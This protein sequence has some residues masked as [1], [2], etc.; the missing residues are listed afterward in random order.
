MGKQR[1]E[2]HWTEEHTKPVMVSKGRTEN[3][4]AGVQLL[5]VCLLEKGEKGKSYAEL[6]L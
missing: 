6:V 2:L 4:R 5:L 3:G 1:G